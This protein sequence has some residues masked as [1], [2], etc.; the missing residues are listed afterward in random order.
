MPVNEEFI[1]GNLVPKS[2]AAILD[3][4]PYAVPS[5]WRRSY[6]DA[7]VKKQGAHFH[8]SDL[9]RP[10]RKHWFFAAV[11]A[12]IMASL[13]VAGTIIAYKR[14][15][16]YEADVRLQVD[17]PG[18]ETFSMAVTSNGPPDLDYVDTQAQVLKSDEL[19]VDV[20]R[21]LHL[22]HNP[23]IIG[24]R[25][26]MDNGGSPD[27][28]QLSE[29]EN[30]ALRHLQST[31]SVSPI[32]NTRVLELKFSS[33]DPQLS[34]SVANALVTLFVERNYKTRYEAV[35]KS[36]QWLERQL[37]DVRQK[38]I[39]SAQTLAAYERNHGIV[40]VDDKQSTITQTISELNH[41]LTQTQAD[42]IQLEP[43]VTDLRS[44]DPDVLPQIRDNP[45]IQALT[46][47]G[48]EVQAELS[49]TKA[50]YGSQSP[51]VKKLESQS[52]A[53]QQ[54]LELQKQQIVKEVQNNYSAARS[55][56]KLVSEQIAKVTS[57]MSDMAGYNNLKRE[58]Q[59]NSD[60]YN[61]L[62]A[63]IKEA[64]ISA[65]SKS[66]N[67]RVF[68][69][70]RVLDKPTWPRPLP[71]IAIGFV[72]SLFGGIAAALIKGS[73]DT[74]I[75]TP[76]E[77]SML[78]GA[79]VSLVP[80]ETGGN[81][82]RVLSWMGL[83]KRPL[84]LNSGSPV[85]VFPQT[86]FSPVAEAMR[87]LQTT[88]MFRGRSKP[89]RVLLVV[90]PF[91]GEGKTTIAVNL[92]LALAST[93][94]TCLIDADL[95]KSR[96]AATF[97]VTTKTGLTDILR[98]RIPPT[99]PLVGI[100]D[101]PNLAILPGGPEVSNPAQLILSKHMG[102]VVKALRKTCDYVVIDSPPLIPFADA[103]ALASL[104]DGMVLVSRSGST[105][106]QAMLRCLEVLEGVGTPIVSVV[107]NGAT[108]DTLDYRYYR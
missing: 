73:F 95:R 99:S 71:S 2:P 32:K 92:A 52:S 108:V 39:Q 97:N 78:T 11:C 51:N 29:C 72:L 45:M 21:G 46:Q 31:I 54:Q 20:I 91:A 16:T 74:T 28:F 48:I 85:R 49:Q 41:Q 89:M 1:P 10:L 59:V 76:A 57:Q 79:A 17:P 70:A 35:M 37:E 19:A 38:M 15:P 103:R 44:G 5:R 22:D 43:L 7:E 33:H 4:E 18:S 84:L 58:A 27:G 96:I 50:V 3:F 106:R 9:L 66:S 102:E 83:A 6:A 82:N 88:I 68:D 40:D 25:P 14:F 56:E 65:A 98:S 64:G 24:D 90:S 69:A 63:R 107:L 62:Y 34:A 80:L 26:C 12:V 93:S 100:P 53:L 75:E 60:L 105:T 94:K 61:T 23:Q 101:V 81:G 55:R 42:R 104:V 77:I 87:S 67:V 47:R 30:I 8:L 36:S 86:S 13:A